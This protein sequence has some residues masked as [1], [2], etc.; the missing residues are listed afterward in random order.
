M[1]IIPTYPGATAAQFRW[2]CRSN[3]RLYLFMRH[4][5]AAA[6]PCRCTTFTEHVHPNCEFSATRECGSRRNANSSSQQCSLSSWSSDLYTP[7]FANTNARPPTGFERVVLVSYGKQTK[8]SSTNNRATG[9][10]RRSINFS[11]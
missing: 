3:L 10:A 9:K 11:Q 5:S 2:P 1:A 4:T 7:Q 8:I 6:L